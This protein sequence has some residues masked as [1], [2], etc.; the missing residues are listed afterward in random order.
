[1]WRL[2]DVSSSDAHA[3]LA[4]VQAFC[5]CGSVCCKVSLSVSSR[6]VVLLLLLSPHT[7][8]HT[9]T[10]LLL[11]SFF[12]SF[13]LSCVRLLLHSHSHGSAHAH[14]RRRLFFH[15]F[16]HIHTIRNV[17]LSKQSNTRA[18]APCIIE[19]RARSRL[20]SSAKFQ[21]ERTPLEPG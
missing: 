16:H 7:P 18:N 6:Q 2:L 14:S 13:V 5:R 17:C 3:V 19:W 4:A 8:T 1:M 15:C 20:N 10:H 9:L 12:R 21:S 11:L